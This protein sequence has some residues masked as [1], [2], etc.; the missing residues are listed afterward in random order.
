MDECQSPS[1]KHRQDRGGWFA[2][3]RRQ[4]QL[5]TSGL[6]VGDDVIIRIKSVRDLGS[7]IDSG[8]TMTSHV[9][10]YSVALF[11]RLVSAT[12]TQ[13]VVLYPSDVVL[14]RL[15]YGNAAS[16]WL[17]MLPPER[18]STCVNELM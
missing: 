3:S 14:T 10:Q 4:T 15:D 7:F 17:L 1:I 13:S 12:H 6:R 16:S 9:T 11:R 18:S 5:P 8:L 2:T